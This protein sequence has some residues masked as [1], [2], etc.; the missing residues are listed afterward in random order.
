MTSLMIKTA[1]LI[2][3]ML[4]VILIGIVSAVVGLIAGAIIGGNLAV[5][6]ELISGHEFVFNGRVGY[7]A[8]GQ[9]G[10]I[11]GAVVG[12]VGSGVL[13]FGRRIKK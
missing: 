13:L 10:F 7:E 6:Y 2:L 5:I 3:R 9:I 12:F 11:L 1:K 8:T 4:A